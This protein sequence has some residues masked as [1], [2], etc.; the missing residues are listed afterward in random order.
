VD[1]ASAPYIKGATLED[2]EPIRATESTLRDPPDWSWSDGATPYR[3]DALSAAILEDES[4]P[5]EDRA[6]EIFRGIVDGLKKFDA[7]G[8]FLGK[9]PRD[10]MLLLLWINDPDDENAQPVMRWVAEMNPK[11]VSEWFNAVYQYR[12]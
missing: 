5:F 9:L 1:D 6:D 10:Q 8:K 3:F 11:P 12:W 7:S 2:I 4:R